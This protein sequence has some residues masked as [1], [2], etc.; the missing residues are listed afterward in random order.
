DPQRLA[1]PPKLRHRHLAAHSLPR[2]RLPHVHILPVRVQR[3]GHP[4]AL[5]PGPQHPHRRPDR[6]LLPQPT[7]RRPRRIV[8]HVHQAAPRAPPFQPGVKASVQLHQLP[9]VRLP[10]PPLP[11]RPPP[12]VPAPQ[13]LRQHP[14]PQRFYPQFNPVFLRQVLGRQRRP[15]SLPHLSPI[16]LTHQ[17]EHPPP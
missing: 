3:L 13:P 4:V 6:L 9:K 11:M 15:K 7:Q 12:P 16:L 17:P 14:T 2:V 8:H 5:H 1:H 10:L